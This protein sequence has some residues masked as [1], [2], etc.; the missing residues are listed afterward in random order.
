M[1]KKVLHA[2][3]VLSKIGKQMPF[4]LVNPE[5]VEEIRKKFLKKPFEPEFSY[6]QLPDLSTAKQ[7]LENLNCGRTF[8]GKLLEEERVYLLKKI[9][10]V[11]SIGTPLFGAESQEVYGLPDEDLVKQAYEFVDMKSTQTGKKIPYEQV[12]D[13]MKETFELLGFTYS[14]R[15]KD[16]VSSAYL[17]STKRQL[18]LKKQARFSRSFAYRLAVHE[19]ATHALR[20]ENARQ[21]ELGLFTR[22]TPNYLAT[23]EGLAAYNEERAGVMN[24]NI[25]RIYAGRVIAVH[26]A[27]THTFVET[28]KELLK[29]FSKEDAFTLTLRAKR[30]L[31]V[32]E[33][34]GG[35]TKDFAYLQGYLSIKEYASQG[36]DLKELYKA[37]IA[38][39]DLEKISYK[40]PE[41]K[42]IPEG[43]IEWVRQ[44]NLTDA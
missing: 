2:D 23:E 3:A 34:R 6:G 4:T 24:T 21:H 39:E 35:C 38:L 13:L 29:H 44:K 33:S 43:V 9:A 15:R 10:F 42:Y 12:K 28:Y 8:Y 7:E 17:S 36:N 14:M 22:G 41:P 31:D 18:Q 27:Q 40:L 11:E 26:L 25:L 30:G 32:G 1:R 5:N 16:M 19:I 20:A 37:K